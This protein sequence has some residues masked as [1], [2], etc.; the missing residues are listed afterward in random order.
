MGISAGFNA[1]EAEAL[2]AIAAQLEGASPPLSPP[3]IPANWTMVYDS[4]SIGPFDN[5]WQLW[6]D[7]GGTGNYAA[8]IRGTTDQDGSILED[9]LSVMVPASATCDID[10]YSLSYRFA[11]D[12]LAAVHLGFALGTLVDGR[13]IP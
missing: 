2:I 9:L 3:P 6:Q 13:L 11:A 1:A 7:T 10:G 4:Q 12:P 5:R 8:V